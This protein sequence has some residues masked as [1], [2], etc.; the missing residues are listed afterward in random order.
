MY[1]YFLPKQR[2]VTQTLALSPQLQQTR[3]SPGLLV[4][5]WSHICKKR[6][7]CVSTL[8]HTLACHKIAPLG[9]TV[10]CHRLRFFWLSLWGESHS[11]YIKRQENWGLERFN[12]PPKVTGSVNTGIRTRLTCN[13]SSSVAV[14]EVVGPCHWPSKVCASSFS[15]L[16]KVC[17]CVSF[18][19]FLSRVLSWSHMLG[20]KVWGAH[21]RHGPE[22]LHLLLEPPNMLSRAV[23]Y[24]TPQLHHLV[25][26]FLVSFHFSSHPN[27][28]HH[29]H[30]LNLFLSQRWLC[31]PPSDSIIHSVPPLEHPGLN[32]GPSFLF[33]PISSKYQVLPGLPPK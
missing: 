18:F 10:C 21:T 22:S 19:S 1:P 13:I 32:C 29:L 14:W 31:H 26:K 9:A 2:D 30:S 8:L 15:F 27:L 6:G 5:L 24:V 16:S 3:K 23:Y 11:I 33:S 12:E 25:L 4:Q 17:V 7:L 20:W 28:N